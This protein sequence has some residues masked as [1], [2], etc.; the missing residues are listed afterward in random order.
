MKLYRC[1]VFHVLSCEEPNESRKSYKLKLISPEDD[2]F[3]A[4]SKVSYP[5]GTEQLL[6]VSFD[7]P[8]VPRYARTC[9]EPANYDFKERS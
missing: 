6:S 3:Y 5:V 2:V 8:I 9:D 7:V 1:D 4:Y